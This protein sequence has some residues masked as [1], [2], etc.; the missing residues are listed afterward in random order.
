MTVSHQ[1]V[2]PAK[3]SYYL[4]E[5]DLHE[6]NGT[7]SLLAR[8]EFPSAEWLVCGPTDHLTTAALEIDSRPWNSSA[9]PD[10]FRMLAWGFTPHS[11]SY[12]TPLVQNAGSPKRVAL[13][14]FTL[15]APKSVSVVWALADDATRRLIEQA[16]QRAAHAFLR[17]LG[18]DSAYS[19]QGRAGR[20]KTPCSLV[21]ALF[22]HFISRS[23]DPQL[24][25][26]CTFLN[27]AVRPDGTTGC[28]ETLDIMRF[29]GVAAT[30]YHEVL[31]E[32][33]QE[34][35]FSI[36]Q[37]DKLFE[38]ESVPEHV[39]LAFSQRRTDALAD[40]T[41]WLS[42]IGKPGSSQTPSR[43]LLQK[44]VLRTRPVKKAYFVDQLRRDWLRRAALLDFHP[45][46][47][48][49]T[50]SERHLE[51]IQSRDDRRSSEHRREVG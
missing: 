3:V 41:E 44:S 25:T 45:F 16:Q 10:D 42:S 6:D 15:S 22:P 8:Q 19:R 40:A 23:A 20:V 38:I 14:D 18:N 27:I 5:Q 24:H 49:Q 46:Q 7:D 9:D 43:A 28:L 31:A 13:H 48:F 1:K 4:R 12:K 17:L 51:L 39:C 21:T 2:R 50:P 47:I 33:M 37:R 30:R 11:G 26:H 34:I 29:I 32:S 35:G 36:Q